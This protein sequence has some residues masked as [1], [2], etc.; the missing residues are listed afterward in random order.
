MKPELCEH[1][2]P[3]TEPCKPCADAKPKPTTRPKA[4]PITYS[5][6]YNSEYRAGARK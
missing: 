1:K 2:V 4:Y 5:R 6:D 3:M